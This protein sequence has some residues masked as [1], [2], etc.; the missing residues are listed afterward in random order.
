MI[1]DYMDKSIYI[2]VAVM[3]VI[4]LGVAFYL[5]SIDRKLSKFEK[6]KI[7]HRDE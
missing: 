3:T 7:E 2:V 6:G 5:F 1:I 4:F